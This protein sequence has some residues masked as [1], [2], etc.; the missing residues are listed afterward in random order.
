MLIPPSVDPK[1]YTLTACVIG[2]VLIDDLTANEQNSIGNWL[3][4]IGQ[5]LETNASQQAVINERTQQDNKS[6][7]MSI[8]NELELMKKVVQKMQQEINKLM[9]E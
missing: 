4:L 6:K 8:E 7:E 9:N 5:V 2:F 1:P 3:M